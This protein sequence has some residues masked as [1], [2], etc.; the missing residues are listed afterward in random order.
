MQISRPNTPLYTSFTVAHKLSRSLSLVILSFQVNNDD[1]GVIFAARYLYYY[2][3][4][5]QGLRYGRKVLKAT[6]GFRPAS[7]INQL[8]YCNRD[9]LF[10]FF[11]FFFPSRR[12][13]MIFFPGRIVAGRDSCWWR[14]MTVYE[15]EYQVFLEWIVKSWYFL[16]EDKK[17]ITLD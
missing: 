17:L 3:H 13:V 10:F 8:F 5:S 16:D 9:G 1:D 4:H 7:E 6:R 11:F 14:K 2:T 15:I 12:T